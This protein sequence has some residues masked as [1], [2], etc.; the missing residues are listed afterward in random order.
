MIKTDEG[1]KN[2]VGHSQWAKVDLGRE[3]GREGGVEI[4][5]VEEGDRVGGRSGDSRAAL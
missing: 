5:R 1:W 2:R 3:G 4:G